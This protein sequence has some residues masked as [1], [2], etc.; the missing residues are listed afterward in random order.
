MGKI[1]KYCSACD[2]GFA[3]TFSFCPNCANELAAFEMKPVDEKVKAQ[4]ETGD[5][6]DIPSE[7]AVPGNDVQ[8]TDSEQL[9]EL[10][11]EADDPGA[12]GETEP[13]VEE[14]IFEPVSFEAPDE[15]REGDELE[16][17]ETSDRQSVETVDRQDDV[18]AATEAVDEEPEFIESETEETA[19]QPDEVPVVLAS[20]QTEEN[21]ES[22]RDEDIETES[23]QSSSGKA[24][25]A[26]ASSVTTLFGA[27]GIPEYSDNAP[28][29]IRSNAKL[30]DGYAITVIDESGGKLRNSLLMA[31]SVLVL[32]VTLGGLVWS[33]FNH[34]L[35]VAAIGGDEILLPIDI[36]PVEIEE[37]VKKE[38]D[39]EG[40]GGGGGGKKEKD[41]A[42]QG[43]LASQS[44]DPITPPSP[45]IPRLT[46]PELVLRQETEGDIRRDRINRTGIPDSLNSGTSSGT[47]SGGG[48]GSG[49]GT[50][51]GSGRGTGEGSG[52]G[53]GSGGGIGDGTGDGR[54]S[55]RGSGRDSPPEPPASGP[56]EGIKIL[57]KPRPG[58]TDSAR[59]NNVQGTVMLRVT[60]MSNGSIGGVAA[61]K[62]LPHGL[63]EKAIAAARQIRFTPAMRNGRPYSVTKRIQYN[64]TI[65]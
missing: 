54:G 53:S 24:A 1:V 52:I 4:D 65:Y 60:F 47:G 13:V 55:G 41:P 16:T 2:E 58:Y 40:G 48:I 43:D 20:A 38:D 14:K 11:P 64:F 19:D 44:R 59:Q 30:D 26:K 61:V 50:G 34:P 10:S 28:G 36:A 3:A 51:I 27:E 15:D 32:S 25:G 57:S 56:T 6:L 5:I 7:E 33:I 22:E 8:S 35:F 46:N 63:T 31:A 12:A 23:D 17:V 18:I 62:G 37:E 49:E 21:I 42:S 9:I 39:E 29:M 45:T